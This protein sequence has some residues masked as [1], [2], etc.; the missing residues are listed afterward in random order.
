MKRKFAAIVVTAAIL[1]TTSA[2]AAPRTDAP[3]P[4][5]N[6]TPPAKMAIQHPQD[7]HQPPQP[8][9]NEGVHRDNPNPPH[10][11]APPAPPHKKH[12]NKV[13]KVLS[14]LLG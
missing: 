3:R 4:Q 1:T 2:F 11:P 13:I 12:G 6:N 14:V 8:H 5:P 7:N 10:K 9:I